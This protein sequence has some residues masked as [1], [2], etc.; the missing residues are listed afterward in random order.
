[1]NPGTKP[2]VLVSPLE[3][4]LGHATRLCRMIN[5]LLE[6]GM[7]VII[8]ADGLPYNF[9]S[10]QFPDL[11]IERLPI[12]QIRYTKGRTGFFVKLFA[13][14]PGLFFSILRSKK[15]LNLLIEKYHIDFIISDNRYGFSHPDIPSVFV[16][17]QLRPVPPKSMIWL[18]SAFGRYHLWMLRKYKYIWVADFKGSESVVGS[19]SALPG[20]NPKIRYIDPLSW[21]EGKSIDKPVKEQYDILILLSGPEPQRSLLEVKV[22]N[23]FKDSDKK[24]LILQGL[25]HKN[26]DDIKDERLGNLRILNH[27]SGEEILYHILNTEILICRAGVVT[28]FDL[29]ILGRS[30]IL[31]PTPGQ[32]EQEYVAERLDRKGYFMNVKQEDFGLQSLEEYKNRTF[33]KFQTSDKKNLDSAIHEFISPQPE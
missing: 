15:K 19:M 12:K 5:V 6:K 4:G 11:P 17:H 1:M 30:A 10:E 14:I 29:A 31:I 23:D 8:V 21:L 13:Q 26:N 28:V 27:L 18:Q 22:L 24:I 2:R 25:P 3:W 32:T 33:K 9:L 20:N 7:D 16:T